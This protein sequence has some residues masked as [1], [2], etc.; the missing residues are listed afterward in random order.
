MQWTP[1]AAEVSV[2]SARSLFLELKLAELRQS[3]V[4][5][6]G[7]GGGSTQ[8]VTGDITLNVGFAVQ[9]VTNLNC[10]V[11]LFTRRSQ[12]PNSSQVGTFLASYNSIFRGEPSDMSTQK[13]SDTLEKS[14]AVKFH[15][16]KRTIAVVDDDPD[17]VNIL[18][19]ILEHNG[20][21]VVCAYSG[22]QLF[23]ILE[24]QKPHLIIL[25]VMM[26]HMHGFEVLN[27]L[28]KNTETSSIPV[29]LVTAKIQFENVLEG[30]KSGADYYIPKP[31]TKSQLMEGI[32]RILS[33]D[34]KNTTGLEASTNRA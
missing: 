2:D 17:L 20:F 25:D 4:A 5:A 7:K 34:K 18:K 19:L 27:R 3:C 9:R 21:N 31:F 33:G 32:N 1:P 13:T 22:R 28:K 15:A 6:T 8:I 10:R 30:Y 23:T 14:A 11:G 29:I 24:T 12:H 16:E 26:P